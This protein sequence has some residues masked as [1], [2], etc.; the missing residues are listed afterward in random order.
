[1]AAVSSQLSAFGK[2]K[3][4]NSSDCFAAASDGLLMAD[5]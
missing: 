1:M 3:F 4:N 2:I 5:C